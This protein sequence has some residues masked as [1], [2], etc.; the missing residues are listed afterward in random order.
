M[1][2]LSKLD[3]IQIFKNLENND[4]LRLYENLSKKGIKM[5]Q[6]YHNVPANYQASIYQDE[7]KIYHFPILI[8]YEEFNLTDY[9]R[10][11]EENSLISDILDVLFQEKLPWDKDNK[12]NLNTIICYYEITEFDT[13]SKKEI[14]YYY[15]LRNDDRLIEVLTNKKVHMNGFPVL[16]IVSQI[17]S[18]YNHFLKNKTVLKRR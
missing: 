11:V 13:N 5:K 18:Y 7:G 3:K 14:N 4:K 2:L 10:D 8:L 15:P 6:Q 12:Y 17:S 1:E 16:V 9:I